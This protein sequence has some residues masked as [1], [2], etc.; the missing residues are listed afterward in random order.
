MI[1]AMETSTAKHE[2]FLISEFPD[3]RSKKPR[4][5]PF[6][7]FIGRI[8]GDDFKAHTLNYRRLAAQ[9]D[10][11]AEAQ[12]LKGRTPCVVT[13]GTCRGGHAVR[14]LTSYSG[15]LCI[16][17]DHTDERTD[18]IVRRVS[19]LPWVVA[20]F[21]SISGNGLKVVARVSPDD[22]ARNY[23]ALYAAVGSAVSTCA[24]HPYDEHCR[25]L[26]QPC[27]YSWDPA[28]WY[29]PEAEVFPFVP[30][31]EAG[32]DADAADISSPVPAAEASAQGATPAAAPG[33]LEQFVSDFEHRHP[34]V[35]GGRNDVAL[36]L[37]HAARRKGFSASELERLIQVFSYRHASND[38]TSD[39]IRSRVLSGY[40]Y[41]DQL[42]PADGSGARAHFR[43]Q[44]HYEPSPRGQ[45]AADADDLL[46]NNETLMSSVPLIPATVY[47]TLPPLL[48]R[49]VEPACNDRERDFLLMGSL[50]SCSALLTGVRFV[51]KG[52]EHS[53]H[54]YL[55][56]VAP[57]GTGKGV[58]A[59]TASLLDATE[60]WYARCREEQQEAADEARTLWE[61]E[62]AE[63]RK[64]QRKPNRDL[65]P[66][67]TVLQYFKLPATIS[68]SRLIESLA[69]SGQVGCAM[70][71]TEMA[72][73]CDAI[74]TD[75]GHFEDI[76]L[77][78]AHHEEVGSSYKVDGAP[79]VARR[80]RLS[81]VMSGTPEQFCTFF[82][83]LESG[84]YS[85][86]AVCT[87]PPAVQWESCAPA[88][89]QTDRYSHFRRLSEELLPI[90]LGLLKSPTL[91]T[92]SP[93]QWREH[94][95]CFSRLLADAHAE[96]RDAVLGIIFRH[97]LL[98]MRLAALFTAFRKWADFRQAPEYRCT[99]TDFRN[100]LLITQTLLEHSLLLS[101]T[102]PDS[103][104][105]VVALQRPH[106]IAVVLESLPAKFSYKQ[107]VDAAVPAGIP[108]SS[109]K[110]ILRKAV[111][112]EL[113]VKEEDG[114]R[115]SESAPVG[116]AH[117]E[118]EP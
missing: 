96:G 90:H 56:V 84:L 100:A 39:D 77:K 13:A 116:K 14:N 91:V 34:F 95:A 35:R 37:G 62:L 113:L 40:Q 41:V 24:A 101:S 2:P 112:S 66:S 93:E 9:P 22:A 47:D 50:N 16:D 18:E 5:I 55:A 1:V 19:T 117:S 58:I 48:T 60:D 7:C 99:D 103:A 28:A 80:P 69:A 27:Y 79:L 67:K 38:F 32:S 78:A 11:K 87:R 86:F 108:L 43:A 30:A 51:Y 52:V 75:Y 4:D 81:L 6:A 110:R 25:I 76:L 83:S 104:R 31:A 17:L 111:Q 97:G 102:L 59:F 36:K 20:A 70:A 44:A 109:A 89:A 106:R 12:A 61:L 74:G 49:C 68:K 107:F 29:A 46:E 63:A 118:P 115:K 98:A 54:F 21:R 57:A 114:Y 105:P 33:F 26:T 45:A 73:L 92:F 53:P 42:P 94:T 15:L 82:R 85:R 10:R 23:R 64:Q 72:T 71:T 8:R 88:D 3:V 65:R